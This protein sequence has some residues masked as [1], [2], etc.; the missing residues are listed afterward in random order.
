MKRE[1]LFYN[2]FSQER[3][4]ELKLS[5]FSSVL[6]ILLTF[7]VVPIHLEIHANSLI[8]IDVTLFAILYHE[9]SRVT[10]NGL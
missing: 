10:F 8:Q 2:P 4:C 6:L 5:C 9:Y 7:Q 3:D 1:E